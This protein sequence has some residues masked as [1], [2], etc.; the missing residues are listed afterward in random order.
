MI[1][2]AVTAQ[3]QAKDAVNAASRDDSDGRK[4]IVEE[5][6]NNGKKNKHR[7]E[8]EAE[9]EARRVSFGKV[10]HSKSHKAS[11]KALRTMPQPKLVPVTPEKSILLKKNLESTSASKR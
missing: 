6:R 7:K 2:K 10:N 11:M 9:K 1:K 4:V 8:T 3:K 5:P